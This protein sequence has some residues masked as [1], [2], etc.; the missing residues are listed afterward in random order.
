M[1]TIEGITEQS[2][3]Q[4][5]DSLIMAAEQ[6]LSR[7]QMRQVG[8]EFERLS[9]GYLGGGSSQAFV[10]SDLGA[11]AYVSA[12]MP[13]IYVVLWRVFAELIE[14]DPLFAP[15]SLVDVG[16]GPGT[17]LWAASARWPS[18]E[19]ATLIDSNEAFR[20]AGQ[21]LATHGIAGVFHQAQWVQQDFES[22]HALLKDADLTCVSYAL[23]E[24]SEGARERVLTQWLAKP[25]GTLVLIEPGTPEGFRCIRD[26]RDLL[27][28]AGAAIIAPCASRAACPMAEG[29]RW[30]HFAQRVER[31][32][33]QRLGKRAV[34]AFEDEK[35]SYLIAAKRPCPNIQ[36]R[37]VDRLRRDK[38]SVT[39]NICDAE[40]NLSTL[41]FEKRNKT[42]FRSIARLCW[43]DA[44]IGVP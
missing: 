1:Q 44:Y 8:D 17:V 3:M 12:R 13:S 24:L 26:A 18:L 21:E 42:A 29:N 25:C 37:V 22:E 28:K 11:A 4:I 38:H 34:L 15:R 41:K 9:S 43:G 36:G 10:A 6:L 27:L 5:P 39:L 7:H 19:H 33:F 14:R 35:Y 32:R 31:T 2:D 20:R 23:G 30:C 16:A 40:G